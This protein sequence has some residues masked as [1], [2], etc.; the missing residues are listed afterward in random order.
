[1]KIEKKCRMSSYIGIILLVCMFVMTLTVNAETSL[2]TGFEGM[3]SVDLEVDDGYAWRKM[4]DE[5]ATAFGLEEFAGTDVYVAGNSGVGQ[6]TVSNIAIT[7]TEPGS[8]EMEYTISALTGYTSYFLGYQLGEAIDTADYN[9][10]VSVIAEGEYLNWESCTI[11]I[12]ESDFGGADYVT[13]YIAYLHDEVYE[14]DPILNF[15]AIRNM[16]YSTGA[17]NDVV[18]FEAGTESMGTV[19]AELMTTTTTK[20]DNGKDITVT[21]YTAADVNAL[22]AGATY[23]LKAAPQSGYQF[24]GWIRNYIYNDKNYTAFYPY[25][26]E[27]T[28]ITVDATTWYR[29]VFAAEGTYYIR[30]GATFYTVDTPIDQVLGQAAAGNI[31]VLVDNYEIPT[32]VSEVRVPAG[33][34]FYIPFREEWGTPEYGTEK[35]APTYHKNGSFSGAISDIDKAYVTLTI[36]EK[37]TLKV[38]GQM[39]LGAE[40][41]YTSQDGFQGHI[42]GRF[43]RIQNNG[44]VNLET[45]STLTCFGLIDGTGTVLAKDGSTVKE[46]L[47]ISDFSGGNNSLQLYNQDQM[48]FKRYSAQNVQC[49]LQM[50]AKSQLTALAVLYAMGGHNEVDVQLLGSDSS[51]VFRTHETKEHTVILDRTYDANRQITS[52]DGN[53][54]KGVGTSTWNINGGLDFQTLTISL[55]GVISLNTA[56]ATFPLPYNMHLSLAGGTYNIDSGVAILPGA[57]LVVENDATL[58]LSGKLYVYDGLVQSALSGDK[59]PTRNDLV[60]AGFS[61]TGEF[62]LNGSMYVHAGASLGGVIQSTIGGALLT[63]EEGT[64]LVNSSNNLMQLDHT[65]TRKNTQAESLY[66]EWVILGRNDV[67]GIT[68]VQNWFL[69]DGGAGHYDDNTTWMNVPARIWDGTSLQQLEAGTYLSKATE[70]V[71]INDSYICCYVPQIAGGTEQGGLTYNTDDGNRY[72]SNGAEIF[73]RTVNGT[74]AAK[75]DGVEVTSI[76][77]AGSDKAGTL[78]EGVTLETVMVDNEDGSTT[79]SIIPKK[80]EIAYTTKMVYLIKCTNVD[81]S[82]ITAEKIDGGW[83]LPAGTVS[84]SI[85]AT[86]L[87]DVT[88]DGKLSSADL[89]KMKQV[90]VNKVSHT[91]LGNLA[92]DVS[93]DGKLSSADLLKYKQWS[94]G[95][96]SEF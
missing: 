84:V 40:R 82:V 2:P 67:G 43:G 50:E 18:Q 87:G 7:V 55:E 11:N 79:L 96:F 51:V 32:S 85:D 42:S 34:T 71:S 4:T 13:I 12:E 37:T 23:R 86:I 10:T 29:P 63:I 69:Q 73:T 22:E 19:T 94:V 60:N 5:D 39:I 45:G 46:S 30:N 80:G 66:D 81:T 33:V 24:Y 91:E 38:N 54:T 93:C 28:E 65:Q 70:G 62:I 44:S 35:K 27:G 88:G 17:R 83:I 64:H 78:T 92:A 52:G 8:L 74:W 89:L 57:S 16:T 56:R 58:N 61:G 25:E 95:K 59:Y 9:S 26:A 31:V 1:M 75:S 3:E 21:T 15:A 76:T 47:V 72:M 68:T 36:Q 48:P 49:R 6:K 77:V 90:S 53:C 41:N 20:D 14:D